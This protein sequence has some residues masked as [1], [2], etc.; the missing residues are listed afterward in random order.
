MLQVL[1]LILWL[2]LLYLVQQPLNEF[3]QR[4]ECHSRT[5][6]EYLTPCIFTLYFQC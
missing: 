4:K 6:F 1:S 3:P 2:S 5:S